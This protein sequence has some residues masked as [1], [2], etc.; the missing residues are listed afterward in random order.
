MTKLL[1][2]RNRTRNGHGA[3][4]LI[5]LLVVIAIIAILA[6]LLLPAL[7]SARD[8]AKQSTCASNLKQLGLGFTMYTGDYNGYFP[9]Y[10]TFWNAPCVQNFAYPVFEGYLGLGLLSYIGSKETFYCPAAPEYI[11]IFSPPGARFPAAPAGEVWYG[12]LFWLNNGQADNAEF[13]GYPPS[14]DTDISPTANIFQDILEDGFYLG[15]SHKR[16]GANIAFGDLH[17]RWETTPSL[18]AQGGI[19]SSLSGNGLRWL[20]AKPTAACPW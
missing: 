13:Y 15:S 14:R 19:H 18:Q 12:Y 11:G 2:S 6:A 1:G 5:E 8:Q 16:T 4:T 17:V 10:S 9:K 20:V 7:S 3:F